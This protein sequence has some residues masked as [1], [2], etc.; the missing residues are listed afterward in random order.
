MAKLLDIVTN[1]NP[2]LRKKSQEVEVSTIKDPKTQR[3]CQDM[4][5][6]MLEKDGVGLAGP[7]VGQNK[8]IIVV[9]TKE[10]PVCMFNPK[11]IKKSWRKEWG[12]EGCLSVPDTFGKVLRHKKAL[13]VFVDKDCQTKSIS[14]EG[15]MARIMQHEIDHLD[16]VLFIDKAKDI[17]TLENSKKQNPNSK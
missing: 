6:T 2:G 15:L 14:C 9:N 3:L 7:Q 10:G 17:K 4:A 8:R 12:E 11:L 1:P 16:G 5:R 13:C